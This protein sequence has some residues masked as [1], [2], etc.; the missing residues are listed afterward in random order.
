M[1]QALRR[2]ESRTAVATRTE[3]PAQSARNAAADER[4]RNA[5]RNASVEIEPAECA[6]AAQ[7]TLG[8]EPSHSPTAPIQ[9]GPELQ[10]PASEPASSSDSPRRDATDGPQTGGIP[11]AVSRDVGDA[12]MQDAPA[13]DVPAPD[14]AIPDAPPTAQDATACAVA[15]SP[16][17]AMRESTAE[18]ANSGACWTAR[19]KKDRLGLAGPD[20]FALA[21]GILARHGNS[22]PATLLFCSVD[23]I[24]PEMAGFSPLAAA[25]AQRTEEEVLVVD[26]RTHS[27]GDGAH[28]ERNLAN[29]RTEEPGLSDV[30][31]GRDGWRSA[32]AHLETDRVGY[33]GPGSSPFV[34]SQAD[35]A[36]AVD[37]LRDLHGRYRYILVNSGDADSAAAAFWTPIC[38]GAYLVLAMGETGREAARRAAGAIPSRGGRILGCV[39][40]RN[41]GH[42]AC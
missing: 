32:V 42:Y 40:L 20:D 16:W 21:E 25:L 26:A 2:I 29:S 17:I 36:V 5:Q 1:L 13:P 23:G 24:G 11:A 8:R 19:K 6:D 34:P 39:L 30:L 10:S 14:A 33:L 37:V 35:A 9:E 4:D 41:V 3:R 38:G 7:P 22:T 12:A 27:V 15:E 31:A 18:F 28:W